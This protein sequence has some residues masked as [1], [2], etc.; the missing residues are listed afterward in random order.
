MYERNQRVE[1]SEDQAKVGGAFEQMAV[2]EE[3]HY[4]PLFWTKQ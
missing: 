1:C 4:T 3:K 2:T